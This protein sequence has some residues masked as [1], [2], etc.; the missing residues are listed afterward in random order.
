MIWILGKRRT[1]DWK[2]CHVRDETFI[3][4]IVF[5]TLEEMMV[6]NI[7]LGPTD[8][9]QFCFVVDDCLKIGYIHII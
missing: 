5:V 2:F 7:Y 8:C 6:Y 1:Q 9:E 4:L 3:L